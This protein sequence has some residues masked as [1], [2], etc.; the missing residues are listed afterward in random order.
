MVKRE[1]R[2]VKAHT[3]RN[4]CRSSASC[5]SVGLV[6]TDL[7]RFV[8]FCLAVGQVQ[9]KEQ[10]LRG[11]LR[12]RGAGDGNEEVESAAAAHVAVGARADE[13]RALHGATWIRRENLVKTG[14]VTPLDALDDLTVGF[15]GRRRKTLQDY[16]I[17]EGMHVKLPRSRRPKTTPRANCSGRTDYGQNSGR[18]SDK[19][20]D[21]RT[22]FTTGHDQGSLGNDSGIGTG[23]RVECPLCAQLVKVYDPAKPD[24]CLSR[25]MD[26]CTRSTRRTSRHR[27]SEEENGSRN[28]DDSGAKQGPAN[29]Q[30]S[31]LPRFAKGG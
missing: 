13:R 2:V 23:S 31:C 8:L 26:R 28:Q 5:V 25:H 30:G 4:T 21:S 22:T 10:I 6:F 20:E 1:G 19:V 15:T 11:L 17:A 14:A 3:A 16:K 27:P 29:R 24:V 18:E 7:L 12:R 9:M